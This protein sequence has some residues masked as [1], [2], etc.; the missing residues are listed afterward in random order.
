MSFVLGWLMVI[1]LIYIFLETH[2]AR[3]RRWILGDFAE[4]PFCLLVSMVPFRGLH[5]SLSVVFLHCAQTAEDID[6]ISF[7]YDS[8]TSLSAPVKIWRSFST[9]F[10]S[11]L[12]G[13]RLL[14][15]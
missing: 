3:T 2:Q 12:A 4:K 9:L 14:V 7:V 15:V 11:C 6:T 5:V 8:A 13:V 1:T 10:T